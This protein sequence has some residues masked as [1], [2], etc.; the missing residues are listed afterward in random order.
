MEISNELKLLVEKNRLSLSTCNSS[1]CPHS[2][3]VSCVKVVS[4]NKVLITDNYMRKTKEN[5]LMNPNVCL[6]IFD[7]NTGYELIGKAKY[8]Q[9]GKYLELAKSI[10]EN[11][12][13]PCKGVILFCIEK[14]VK[15]I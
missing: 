11:K 8:F 1:F 13:C 7:G 6:S 3:F 4:K 10:P 12:G 15:M 2:I 9:N 14:V 5:V